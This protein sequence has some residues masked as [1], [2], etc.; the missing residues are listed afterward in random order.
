MHAGD[1]VQHS[2]DLAELDPASAD[3]H[4]M[5]AA[6]DELE[7]VLALADDVAGAV[8]PLPALRRQAPIPLGIKLGPQVV[9]EPDAADHELARLAVGDEVTIV[10]DDRELPAPQRLAD[11]HRRAGL[12]PNRGG[13]DGCLGRAVGIPQLAARGQ[14]LDQVLGARLA[15]ENQQPDVRQRVVVPD[16]RQRGDGRDHRDPV[17]LQPRAEL[18]AGAHERAWRRDEGGAVRPREPHLLAARVERDGQ[19]RKH[20]V[21]GKYVPQIVLGPDE[22]RRG[23]MLHGHALGLPGRTR[24]ED[25][26]RVVVWGRTP[27]AAAGG[28][29]P[30]HLERLTDHG[31]YAGVGEDLLG[32]GVG[33]VGVDRHIC[34]ARCEDAEDRDVEVGFAA[35]D[36][37][38]DAIARADPAAAEPIGELVHLGREVVVG[39]DTARRVDRGALAPR[40][41]RRLEDVDQSQLEHSRFVARRLCRGG[42]GATE[43]LSRATRPAGEPADGAPGHCMSFC[44]AHVRLLFR[45]RGR[46]ARRLVWCEASRGCGAGSFVVD[47]DTCRERL[48]T[49]SIS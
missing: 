11:R 18:D 19:A 22:R 1:R 29:A 3:L 36:P 9:T 13:Y 45:W 28:S 16:P 42:V 34:R 7:A 5:I 44:V 30:G 2:V 46:W 10:I 20:A 14:A 24:R 37:H 27:D 8:R 23:P 26:P 35:R 32:A 39:E 6:P 33:I 17:L 40:G 15:A 48:R 31:A 43:M 21:L 49:G 47:Y 38:A 25:D 12:E 4:L 41:Y